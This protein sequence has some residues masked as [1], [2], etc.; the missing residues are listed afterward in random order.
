[1]I[2]IYKGYQIKPYKISPSNYIVAVDGKGGS[3]P[4][5]LDTLFTS[6]GIAKQFIDEYL[7]KKEEEIDA[8]KAKPTRR[9]K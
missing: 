1:M 9:G 4:S 8:S 6:R 5:V 3:I 2:E 7:E